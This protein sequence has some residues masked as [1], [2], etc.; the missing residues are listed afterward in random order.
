MSGIL[1]DC[2]LGLSL[3]MNIT[4]WCTWVRVFTPQATKVQDDLKLER[5]TE[6]SKIVP[7][8][9]STIW[10][11]HLEELSSSGDGCTEVTSRALFL[12]RPQT[13]TY[14]STIH[15]CRGIREMVSFRLLQGHFHPRRL[16]YGKP[17]SLLDST[18][19]ELPLYPCSSRS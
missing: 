1:E 11:T 18:S 9:N 2:K 17:A 7:R 16:E 12:K 5:V 8:F 4:W 6:L 14:S 13:T 19:P 10:P 3:S 15:R